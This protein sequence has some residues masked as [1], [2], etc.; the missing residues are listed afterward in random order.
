MRRPGQRG[1]AGSCTVRHGCRRAEDDRCA[2]AGAIAGEVEHDGDVGQ[3]PVEGVLLALLEVRHARGRRQRRQQDRGQDLVRSEVVF[4]LQVPTRRDEEILE[5]D[6]AQG[7]VGIAEFDRRA[8]GHQH[9]RG[10]RRMDDRASAVVEDRVIRVLAVDRV[11]VA[12]ALAQAAERGGAEVPAARPLQQVA[13]QGRDMAD[14]RARSAGGRIAKCR[15]AAPHE[16]VR[17]QFGQR[18]HRADA[19]AAVGLFFD[20]VQARNG[21]QADQHR[22]RQQALLEQ[23]EQIDAAGL[24][25]RGRGC[26]RRDGR[27][28]GRAHR[29][30]D[31]GRRCRGGLA[32][33]SGGRPGKGIHDIRPGAGARPSAASTAAG[34]IGSDRS[35]TPIAL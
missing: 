23:I 29:V 30:G 15:V 4:P 13:A 18:D 3:R 32:R 7:A 12:A 5:Q 19:Q 26:R 28:G 10:G 16:R 20:A 22:R 11:A 27:T 31:R 17:G 33:G 24:H 1:L 14:L 9:R 8:Q 21:R 35:R 2:P 25:H 34:V 6:P